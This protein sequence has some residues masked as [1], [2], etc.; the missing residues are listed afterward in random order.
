MPRRAQKAMKKL[1]I[2]AAIAAT[3]SLTGCSSYGRYVNQTK[4]TNLIQTQVVLSNA[5]FKVVKNVQATVLYKSSTFKFN[6]Q[7]MW[8]SAYATLLKEANLQGSQALINVTV[9]QVQRVRKG[10]LGKEPG[11]YKKGYQSVQ[12]CGTVIEFTK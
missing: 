10:L 4:N 11:L 9:E 2:F 3:L 1:I 8:N 6:S 7:Q 5:N 12:V